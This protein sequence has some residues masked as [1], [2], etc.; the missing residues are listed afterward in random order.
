M[1]WLIM[2]ILA[3]FVPISDGFVPISGGFVPILILSYWFY[4]LFLRYLL[5]PRSSVVS[6]VPF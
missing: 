3:W 2:T 4:Y 5:Y 6:I 1:V